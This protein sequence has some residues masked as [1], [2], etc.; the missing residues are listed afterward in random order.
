MNFCIKPNLIQSCFY[1]AYEGKLE[2]IKTETS[3]CQA[4]FREPH[5]RVADRVGG[6]S[7][8]LFI[9]VI[10]QLPKEFL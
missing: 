8:S 10:L 1:R 3:G 4:L 5:C 7:L 6:S 2:D 9:T